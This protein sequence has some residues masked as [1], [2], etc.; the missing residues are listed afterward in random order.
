MLKALLQRAG[1][2]AL[3]LLALGLATS[4]TALAA[5]SAETVASQALAVAPAGESEL[6]KE[7]KKCEE[8][9]AEAEKKLKENETAIKETI[10]KEEAEEAEVEAAKKAAREKMT[11]LERLNPFGEWPEPVKKVQK[12]AETI[13]K[14]RIAEEE[15]NDKEHNKFLNEHGIF[16]ACYE[17]KEKLA[18]EKKTVKKQFEVPST[19]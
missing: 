7:V 16:S 10:A 9:Q 8:S 19:Q 15:A 18:E 5:G 14:T 1:V 3:L 17:K 13:E 6:E 11:W 2:L 12:E 4:G